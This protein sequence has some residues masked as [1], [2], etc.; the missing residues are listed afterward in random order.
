MILPPKLYIAPT[1]APMNFDASI[2]DTV[3]TFTWDPPATDSQNGDIVSYFLSC[4]INSVE[5]F[6]L[7]LTSA[8]EEISLG[9]YEV[10]STYTCTI[11]ASN[12][13]GEGPTTSATAITGGE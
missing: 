1:G 9:V 5:Q 11:S 13:D 8:V 6:E 2:E 3:L 7:N 12:S 4:S 10:S